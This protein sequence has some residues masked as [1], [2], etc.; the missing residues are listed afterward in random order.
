M[1]QVLLHL[2]DTLKKEL[3]TEATENKQ[4]IESVIIIALKKYLHIARIEKLRQGLQKK[5]KEAGFNSEE[6]VFNAI[7]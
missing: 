3:E 7:S 2:D 1:Q 6:D 4:D 5:A